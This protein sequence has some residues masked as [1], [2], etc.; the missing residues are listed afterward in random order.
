MQTEGFHSIH[1][2]EHRRAQA[3]GVFE[4]VAR[5]NNQRE[6][7]RDYEGVVLQCLAVLNS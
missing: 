7:M 2:S 3:E 6:Q 1:Q 5:L 4:W